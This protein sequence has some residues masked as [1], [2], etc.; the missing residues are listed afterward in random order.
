VLEICN[1]SVNAL[2]DCA[3]AERA[4]GRRRRSLQSSQA[5]G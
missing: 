1:A 3:S 5:F 2:E 4:G